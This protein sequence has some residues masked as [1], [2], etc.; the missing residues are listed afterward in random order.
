[1]YV[2]YEYYTT[3]YFGET[4]TE[5]LFPKYEQLARFE[6]DYFTQGRLLSET[7]SN[8]VK[9]AMC[10]IID[11]IY[12]V[13]QYKKYSAVDT[14]EK[15][16][17]SISAG[18]ESITYATTENSYYTASINNAEYKNTIMFMLSKYLFNET[19]SNGI[20]LLYQGVENV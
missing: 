5:T 2:N 3:T 18:S 6:V 12:R 1:M 16:V 17:K 19:D 4:V 15:I 8:N 14:D 20:L 10:D 11:F 13:D 7:I 9:M